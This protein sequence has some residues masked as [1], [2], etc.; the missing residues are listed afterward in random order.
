MSRRRARAGGIVRSVAIALLLVLPGCSRHLGGSFVPNV[1]PELEILD[2][3]ADRTNPTDVRVRWAAR[4][5]DGSVARSCWTMV[6]MGPGQ[7]A[8]EVTSTRAEECVLAR[9]APALARVAG[10][11]RP[12]PD[13]FT[14]WA[15]DNRGTE[16]KRATVAMFANNIAPTVYISCPVPSELVRSLTPCNFSISWIG[17]DPD[18]VHTTRP[19]KYKYK[20]FVFGNPEFDLNLARANPDSLRRYYAA[21]A[22]AGW[23]STSAD[24]TSIRLLNLVPNTE[25]LFVV[26]A[27]DEVGDY[28]PV[29]SLA[30]NMLDLTTTLQFS[31]PTISMWNSEFFYRYP[32]GG[33]SLDPWAVVSVEVPWGAP[34]TVNV[35][36]TPPAGD[37]VQGYRWALDAADPH[38]PTVRSDPADLRHWSEWSPTSPQ[39]P[40]G[41]FAEPG[42]KRREHTLYI[43][44]MS[45]WSCA[46]APSDG[47]VSLGILHFVVVRP[48]SSHELLI[49]DDTR[50]EVDQFT[51]GGLVKQYTQLW[52]AAAELDTFLYARGGVPWRGTQVPPATVPQPVSKPGLFAGYSYDT[53]GTRGLFSGMVTGPYSFSLPNG[54][55]PLS[56][57]ADYRHVIW[58]TD[59]TAASNTA[60]FSDPLRPMSALRYMNTPNRENVLGAYV[61]MGGKVWLL[62][63]GAAYAS[64]IEYNARG[65]SN[66]DAKYGTAMTVF[67][68]SPPGYELVPGR[69]MYDVAHVQSEMVTMT[70]VSTVSTSVVRALGRFEG[71]PGSYAMLPAALRMRSLVLGDSLPPTR[72]SGPQFY[73]QTTRW[74]EFLTQPN[75]IIENASPDP[76]LYDP[77]STLDSLYKL[78]GGTLPSTGYSPVSMLYYHGRENSNFVWTGFDIWSF[79]RSDCQALVDGV[80]QG[81]WGM[82]RGPVPQAPLAA[83]SQVSW[84]RVVD[85]GSSSR[86]LP[87]PLAHRR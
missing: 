11:A 38:D 63:G 34:L 28:D 71:N 29:F 72:L 50:R 21:I 79:T 80:L 57:L 53:I 64:L 3:R 74:A 35:S 62:G 46:G 19:L 47:R 73:G 83:S 59:Q 56:L 17:N 85:A 26:T 81:I 52:P 58:M 12:E 39:I 78:Q 43:E 10:T 51:A 66:N 37:V 32:A 13:L 24:T 60:S 18:G 44:A 4:D 27:F 77:Q 6:Q 1:P 49:V 45:G 87:A 69:L 16:S 20:L 84:P 25:Y 61:A 2:A 68:A 65:A 5:P 54:T 86:A 22:W 41:V 75:S 76:N 70:T 7:A 36:A 31:G 14:V 82:Q 40:L 30:K 48:T 42:F 8:G 67:S 23:D 9:R 15:V 55:I 33:W